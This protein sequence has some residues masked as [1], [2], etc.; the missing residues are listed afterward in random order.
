MSAAPYPVVPT[1]VSTTRMLL[2]LSAV[3][4]GLDQ[5][6]RGQVEEGKNTA[7]LGLD[8]MRTLLAG[9]GQ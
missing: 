5:I 1:T 9:D 8:F 3:S 7:R 4:T 2:G 6:E